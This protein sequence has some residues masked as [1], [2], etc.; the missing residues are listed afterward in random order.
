MNFSLKVPLL[1]FLLG[2][3]TSLYCY[4][5]WSRLCYYLIAKLVNDF[6]NNALFDASQYEFFRQNAMEDVELGV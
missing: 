3:Q 5:G 1:F 6:A 2:Y 4:P